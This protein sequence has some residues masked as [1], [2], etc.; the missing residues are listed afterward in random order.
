MIKEEKKN[1]NKN[2]NLRS[3]IVYAIISIREKKS[4]FF[5]RS[6]TKLKRQ[7][8]CISFSDCFFV[9]VSFGHFEGSER[10]ITNKLW[11]EAGGVN[12]SS[13]IGKESTVPV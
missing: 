9:R 10:T 4:S 11:L 12:Y 8:T 5:L 13:Y 3:Y 6:E 2:V 1:N 7:M